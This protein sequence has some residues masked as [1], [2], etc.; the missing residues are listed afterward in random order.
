LCQVAVVAWDQR[1]FEVQ[2]A[3]P[4]QAQ[5]IVETYRGSARFPAGDRRLGS[6]SL[7]GKRGLGQ[8]GATPRFPNQITT[9]RR[10]THKYNSAAMFE[11]GSF[12]A[13]RTIAREMSVRSARL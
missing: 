13:T 5:Y 8:T 9:V 11:P 12:T 7:F 2:A 10:H 3:E 6:A 1:D 4:H